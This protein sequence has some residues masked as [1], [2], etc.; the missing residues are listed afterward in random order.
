MS[1]YVFQCCG[2]TVNVPDDSGAYVSMAHLCLNDVA[3][4]GLALPAPNAVIAAI[5]DVT[6]EAVDPVAGVVVG[7]DGANVTDGDG[8]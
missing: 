7:T 2:R 4:V 8:Q 6:T 3:C 1:Q 5:M